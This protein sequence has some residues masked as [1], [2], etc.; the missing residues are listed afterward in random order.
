MVKLTPSTALT[1]PTTL[2]RKPR[3]MGKYFANPFT[4][5][6]GFASAGLEL[7]P[8]LGILGFLLIAPQKTP[9]L[10]V[11]DAHQGWH[12]HV[13]GSGHSLR[14]PVKKATAA[15]RIERH[16]HIAFDDFE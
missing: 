6:S 5:S 12:R 14:A 8:A 13:T 15:R 16:G 4:S 11:A 9:D 7:D 3:S 1:C 10:L 2:R